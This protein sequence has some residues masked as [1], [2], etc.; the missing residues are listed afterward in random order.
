MGG[1]VSHS[2]LPSLP[3]QQ[4]QQQAPATLDVSQKGGSE[5][6]A[7]RTTRKRKREAGSDSRPKRAALAADDGDDGDSPTFTVRSFYGSVGATEKLGRDVPRARS[8]PAAPTRCPAKRKP[9]REVPASNV[10]ALAPDRRTATPTRPA[11]PDGTAAPTPDSSRRFFRHKASDRRRASGDVCVSMRKGFHLRYQPAR[12]RP[13]SV[14]C[15]PASAQRQSLL[16]QCQP[17]PAQCQSVPAQC[18]SLPAQCQPVPA[19]C[20]PAPAQCQPAPAQC[21]PLPAQCQ[22]AVSP[23]DVGS[24]DLFLSGSEVATPT[25]TAADAPVNTDSGVVPDRSVEVHRR[26][27]TDSLSTVSTVSSLDSVILLPAVSTPKRARSPRGNLLFQCIAFEKVCRT[28]HRS[29]KNVDFAVA[30]D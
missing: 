27:D 7:D 13:A 8:A 24:P 10:L 15:R 4:Q 16:A 28:M 23:Q 5:H 22:L 30:S 17:A 12:C 9:L 29:L 3:G 18:Q 1:G 6:V 14:P 2:V 26:P 20:Q 25:L 11:P 19:Q 21:Q